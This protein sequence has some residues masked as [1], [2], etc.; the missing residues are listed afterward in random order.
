MSLEDSSGDL[1]KFEAVLWAQHE[2]RCSALKRSVDEDLADI[3]MARRLDVEKR[4]HDSRRSC[5]KRYEE[6]VAANRRRIELRKKDLE[7]D[8]RKALLKRMEE[9]LKLRFEE[10]RLSPAYGQVMQ[11]LFSEARE[12]FPLPSVL[13]L[14]KGDAVFLE[15]EGTIEG[16]AEEIREDL[17]DVW[18]GLVLVEAR[19]TRGRVFDNTFRARWNRLLPF[20]AE[21]AWQEAVEKEAVEKIACEDGDDA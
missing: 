1:S 18:G 6:G 16:R 5:K 19:K 2:E 8:L 10:F 21:R 17:K 11:Y 13:L 9:A 7:A 3:I 20:F 15:A 14:E 12:K 4:V